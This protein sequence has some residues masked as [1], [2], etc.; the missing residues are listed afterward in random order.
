MMIRHK[1]KGMGMRLLNLF[2]Q[3]IGA[4]TAGR[5]KVCR[6]QVCKKVEEKVDLPGYGVV[7]VGCRLDCE[8]EGCPRPQL[9]TLK[10]LDEHER[11]VVVEI[12]SDNP[13]VVETIPSMMDM[14]EGQHLATVKNADNWHIYVRREV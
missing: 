7:E 9:R 4:L 13:S 3:N 5:R 12:I 6:R 2:H 10:A 11:G 8:G 14:F 1:F